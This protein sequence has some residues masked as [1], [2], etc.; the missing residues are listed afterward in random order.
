MVDTNIILL[1]G[2]SSSG[3]TSIAI[4]LQRHLEEPYLHLGIDTVFT[5]IPR[6]CKCNH[7][8]RLKAFV[9]VPLNNVPPEVGISVGPLGERI[10]SAFHKACATLCDSGVNLILDHVLL[11][12]HWSEE[13]LRLFSPYFLHFIGVFCPTEVLEKRE[14]ERGDR[15]IGLARYTAIRAHQGKKY[16]LEV[17]TSSFTARECAEQIIHHMKPA[18]AYRMTNQVVVARSP[19]WHEKHG[20][21]Q[22]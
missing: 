21:T 6:K 8:E 19:V 15:Q 20:A 11:E 2:A 10:M 7:P 17:D 16:D 9:W 4:E 5:M 14:R 13:C 12:S 22:H 3:K 1:N 18:D